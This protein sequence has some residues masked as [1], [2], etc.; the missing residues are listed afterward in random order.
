M[1]QVGSGFSGGSAPDPD[2]SRGSD[3]DPDFSQGSDPQPYT[4]HTN[5]ILHLSQE[6]TK[7]LDAKNNASEYFV[8]L[9]P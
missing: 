4:Q 3:P 8:A 1:D 2:Y 6:I 9:H 5:V 7:A